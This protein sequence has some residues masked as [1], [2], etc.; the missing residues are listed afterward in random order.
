MKDEAVAVAAEDERDFEGFGIAECLLDA[1]SDSVVVVFRLD[2]G[3]GDVGLVVE[4]IV[5]AF[6]CAT[7]VEFSPD[8]DAPI[9]EGD[10]LANLV[11]DVPTRRFDLGRD[12]LCADVAFAEVFFIH[13]AS[14]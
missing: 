2:D 9:G 13:A 6:L 11:L 7:G 12:E 1:C 14:G 4:N 10:F 3:D 8:I 5:S